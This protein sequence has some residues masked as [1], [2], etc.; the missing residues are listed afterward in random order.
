MLF[1]EITGWSI[2][3]FAKEKAKVIKEDNF[4]QLNKTDD[5]SLKINEALTK[6]MEENYTNP[7]LDIAKMAQLLL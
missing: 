4:I 7:D 5:L 1:P 6:V 3:S 2:I